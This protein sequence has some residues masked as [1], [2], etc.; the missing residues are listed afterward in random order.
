MSAN[1]AV[2]DR[3]QSHVDER[4][5][6]FGPSK[7]QFKASRTKRIAAIAQPYDVFVTNATDVDL[8]GYIFFDQA[9]DPNNVQEID[10]PLPAQTQDGYQLG[11][12]TQ[13]DILLGYRL[14]VVDQN[15]TIVADTGV[16]YGHQTPGSPCA[17]Y[18]VI[19]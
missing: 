9:P 5:K 18:W 11:S 17:D 4:L 2:Q 14:V 13:C 8:H 3:L 19:Q 10:G 12:N 15:N 1:Q 16:V 7:G 6:R